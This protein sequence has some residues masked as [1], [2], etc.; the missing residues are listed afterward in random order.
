MVNAVE[1]L[2][3]MDAKTFK[4]FRVKMSDG[5]VY[6]V[7]HHDAAL[8]TRNYLEIGTD[9]DSNKIPGTVTRCAI[10]H[11]TQIEDLQPA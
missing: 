2:K 4:P 10:I 11:I 7:P 8:V 6:D 9:L 5:S 3:F 1:L